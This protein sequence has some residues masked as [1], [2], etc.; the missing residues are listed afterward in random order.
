MRVAIA[1]KGPVAVRTARLLAALHAAGLT[2]AE[3]HIVPDG[4]DDG[5]DGWLPSLAGLARE[6]G[7]PVQPSVA[8]CG[9]GPGD[10]LLSLQHDRILDV[11][12]LAG[13]R[14]Y[15]LHFAE[16]PGYRGVHTSIW[17]LRNG[18]RTAAVTLHELTDTVDGGPVVARRRF[19]LP[20]FA[21]ARDLYA[22]AHAH[23]F[24][25]L[26]DELGRV[27]A[28]PVPAAAQDEAEACTYTRAELDLTDVELRDFTG[29]A[30]H[31]RDR[32]RSLIFPP[33]QLPRFRGHPVRACFAL[34]WA[35]GAPAGT[36][37][38]ATTDEILVACGTDALVLEV[39]APTPT[40]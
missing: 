39:A 19:E 27:L 12:S 26:K 36:V 6:R 17:P 25:L 10:L 5:R 35:T 11:A 7:W 20:P 13:V 24:E 37:L 16:L 38:S 1:G 34:P 31:V 29:T 14:A 30:E 2:P 15:N 23:G 8:A 21:T 28:G 40:P 18:E 22:A 33:F 32:C 9:L 4:G 3:L